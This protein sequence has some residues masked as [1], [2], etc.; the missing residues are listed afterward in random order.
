[1]GLST[2]IEINNDFLD[3]IEKHPQLF[4]E[5]IIAKINGYSTNPSYLPYGRFHGI[6][7]RD[8]DIYKKF[9]KLFEHKLG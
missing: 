7:H 1:M 2:I 9:R 8:S 3:K 5:E 4:A 6:Y